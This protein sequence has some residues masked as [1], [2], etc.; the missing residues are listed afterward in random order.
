MKTYKNFV[1]TNGWRAGSRKF[2]TRRPASRSR[3][4]PRRARW[5]LI[6]REAAREHSTTRTARFFQCNGSRRVLFKMAE[7]VRKNARCCRIG[8]AQLR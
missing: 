2:S 7:L 4:F 6:A 5:T 3:L 1:T 8:D